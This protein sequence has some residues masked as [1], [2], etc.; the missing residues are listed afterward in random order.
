MLMITNDGEATMRD[1]NFHVAIVGAGMAGLACAQALVAGGARVTLFDKARGAGGRMSSRRMDTPAGEVTFDHGAQYFTARDAGF[2]AQVQDWQRS[3]VVAH[4]PAA[5]DDAFVGAPAMNAPLKDMADALAVR[6]STRVTSMASTGEGWTLQLETPV[7]GD[8]GGD[9][10]TEMFNV[11]VVAIPAEQAT[12]LLTGHDDA[13]AFSAA[14]AKTAPCWTLMLAFSAAI[15]TQ[16]T[17]LRDQG[18]IG[19]ACRNSAKPGRAAIETWVVQA[20][21]AWS[22]AHLEETAEAVADALTAALREALSVELPAV[23]ARSAHRWR[24]A[25][26]TQAAGGLLWDR[27]R[28]IGVCGDWLLGPRVECAWL[29]GRA[30]AAEILAG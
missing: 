19:W 29:S 9:V 5:G 26:A 7:D 2:M 21:A 10:V 30:L 11:V 4:W 25:R 28:R 22:E 18:T 20:S 24:Y 17:P 27:D 3:G 8:G 23:L 16:D 1:T 12:L 14:A 13:L 15:K 6:W